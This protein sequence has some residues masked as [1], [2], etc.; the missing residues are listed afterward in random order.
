[1]KRSKIKNL[2][3]F[4]YDIELCKGKKT[5]GKFHDYKKYIIEKP[6]GSEFLAYQTKEVSLWV[7]NLKPN[8]S[9]SLH[10]HKLK[11]TYLIPINNSVRMNLL[12]KLY[13]F[14]KKQ[15]V[16][17]PKK[18]FHQSKNINKSMLSLIEIELPNK[19]NDIIR[20][21]DYYGRKDNDFKKENRINKLKTNNQFFNDLN[22]NKS[23][24]INKGVAIL[25]L[26]IKNDI[27]KAIYEMFQY[28]DNFFILNGNLRLVNENGKNEIIKKFIFH[29]TDKKKKNKFLINKETDILFV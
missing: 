27:N 15:I 3:L 6:W 26:K 9:T 1:M 21:H 29:K 11:D 18:K 13:Y 4:E 16:F 5:N 10:A 17:I 24:L 22:Q 28:F 12:E 14:K 19:K 23:F 7:L 8:G 2:H 25:S 20:H